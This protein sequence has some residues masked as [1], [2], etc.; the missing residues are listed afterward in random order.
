[1]AVSHV[2]T[3]PMWRIYNAEKFF[4]FNLG[5]IRCSEGLDPALLT[6]FSRLSRS[7]PINK[8]IYIDCGATSWTPTKGHSTSAVHRVVLL[9][10][11]TDVH[12]ST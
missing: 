5:Y 6:A 11:N 3:G 4:L 9:D 7:S 1:M 10:T 2:L 12:P 8:N